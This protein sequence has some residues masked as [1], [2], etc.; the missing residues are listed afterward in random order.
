MRPGRRSC[1][2]PTFPL[3]GSRLPRVSA[4]LNRQRSILRPFSHRAVVKA[5]IVVAE[6]M[7]QEQVDG[8]RDAAA[9]IGDHALVPGYALACELRL[10]VRE[11]N[12]GLGLRVKQRSRGYVDAAGNAPGPAV[13][14]WLQTPVE[15]RAERID[16][17]GVAISA[18]RKR[19]VLVDEISPLGFRGEARRWISLRWPGFY[20]AALRSPLVQSAVQHGNV[21]KTQRTQ[22]PPESRRP[23]RRADAV[24]HHLTLR[25]DPM[26]T[27]R[28]L[29]LRGR[30]HHEVKR[31]ILVGEFALQIQKIRSRNVPSLKGVPSGHG[32]I[33]DV[34]AGRLIFEVGGTIE[35]P[36]IGLIED[37][38]EFRGRNKLVA[39]G[40]GLTSRECLERCYGV[41]S[42]MKSR[43]PVAALP[44]NRGIPVQYSVWYSAA[45]NLSLFGPKWPG[46]AIEGMDEK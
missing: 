44:F 25:A 27:K 39:L 10:C 42:T 14:A 41:P 23:H 11:R 22:H 46:E 38:G 8:G 29:K 2:I 17:D 18:R 16:D 21:L 4:G 36:Q 43:P 30:R 31:R 6:P 5:E 45:G 26:A 7:Q 40:H 13:T 28:G 37:G 12:K 19:L 24:E 1:P 34:A 32:N 20:G 15:L 35:Q 3:D 9:A 33:G